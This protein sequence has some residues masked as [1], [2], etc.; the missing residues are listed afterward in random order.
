MSGN[1]ADETVSVGF[2]LSQDL[3]MYINGIQISKS[4]LLYSTF[5]ININIFVVSWLE[6]KLIFSM[7]I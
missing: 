3:W 1:E 6:F 2:F 4:G 7:C 5:K